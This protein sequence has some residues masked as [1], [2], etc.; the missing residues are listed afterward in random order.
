MRLAADPCLGFYVVPTSNPP[1]SRPPAADLDVPAIAVLDSD[2]STDDSEEPVVSVDAFLRRSALTRT[3]TYAKKSR[4]T[5]QSANEESANPPRIELYPANNTHHQSKSLRSRILRAAVLSHADP[6]EFLLQDD[7]TAHSRNPLT[8]VE[9]P[10]PSR[11]PVQTKRRTWSLV[12]PRKAHP[13]RSNSFSSRTKA[14]A[15]NTKR[16]TLSGWQARIYLDGSTITKKKT[17][18]KPTSRPL[19]CLPLSFVPLHEAE[20]LYSLMRVP[21][22]YCLHMH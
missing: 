1:I 16:N 3:K 21:N 11:E 14:L 22:R 4:R 8:F 18:S 10:H 7:S 2:G 13:A 15:R 6:D 12:D 17:T 5:T 20:K 9:G 19:A